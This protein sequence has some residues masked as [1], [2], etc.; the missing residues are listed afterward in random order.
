MAWVYDENQCKKKWSII[1]FFSDHFWIKEPRHSEN[2]FAKKRYTS[3]VARVSAAPFSRKSSQQQQFLPAG[4][5]TSF[6]YSAA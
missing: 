2:I 4:F 1:H 6:L 3:I 5:Q